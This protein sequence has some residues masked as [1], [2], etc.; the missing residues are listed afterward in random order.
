MKRSVLWFLFRGPKCNF[1]LFE[2]EA[3]SGFIDFMDKFLGESQRNSIP[4]SIT[5]E[6][7]GQV[8]SDFGRLIYWRRYVVRMLSTKQTSH[9]YRKQRVGKQRNRSYRENGAKWRRRLYERM[10]L[11]LKVVL[12]ISEDTSLSDV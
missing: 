1:W 3:E 12:V 9:V 11:V 8:S 5:I 7:P 10:K 2:S 4:L 6:A